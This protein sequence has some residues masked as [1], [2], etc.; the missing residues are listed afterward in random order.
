MP[1]IWFKPCINFELFM[2]KSFYARIPTLSQVEQCQKVNL[3]GSVF[4]NDLVKTLWFNVIE[5][6]YIFSVFSPCFYF[7]KTKQRS[8]PNVRYVFASLWKSLKY[9]L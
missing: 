5:T 9:E 2:V 1:I 8:L 7:L 6:I 3:Y 4:Y